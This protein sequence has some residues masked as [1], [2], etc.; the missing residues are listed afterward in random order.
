MANLVA[1]AE[2]WHAAA[3]A[4]AAAEAAAAA[5]A[6]ESAQAE[7]AAAAAAEATAAAAVAAAAAAEA[8]KN[9]D[10]FLDRVGCSDAW[11]AGIA[12]G[13]P[14][15][16]RLGAATASPPAA[17]P[18]LAPPA[19]GAPPASVA[20]RAGLSLR[21]AARLANT[22]SLFRSPTYSDRVGMPSDMSPAPSPRG[23]DNQRTSPS[24]RRTSTAPAA[25]PAAAGSL[26][27]TI[28]DDG[29]ETAAV[30]APPVAA[31]QP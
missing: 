14:P 11:I 5:A 12:T 1:A 17:A 29:L 2:E 18:P 31:P 20:P 3:D 4:D 7:A 19:G 6:A 16:R 23:G 24:S 22:P 26:P 13:S 27:F 21:V 10:A 25:F 9:P 15:P 8:R 30:P 28:D